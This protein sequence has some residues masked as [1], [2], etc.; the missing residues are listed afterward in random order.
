GRATVVGEQT[1]GCV[2]G[3]ERRQQLPDGGVLDISETDYHT[4]AGERLEGAG[5]PPDVA[6]APTREDLRRRRDR[7]LEVAEEILKG[8]ETK[9]DAAS[10]SSAVPALRVQQ[11]H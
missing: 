6:A 10:A 9:P 2:L 7:A 4:A 3:I 8:D 1:C 5:L 11:E